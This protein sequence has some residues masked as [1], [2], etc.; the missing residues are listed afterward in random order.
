LVED[1]LAK[2]EGKSLLVENMPTASS[3]SRMSQFGQQ[4]L[5]I[6][7]YQ[8]SSR[9]SMPKPMDEERCHLK[10]IVST[11]LFYVMLQHLGHFVDYK[12][13][14]VNHFVFHEG[15]R[16]DPKVFGSQDTF[17]NYFDLLKTDSY[18]K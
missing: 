14:M 9:Q 4:Q 10:S 13:S 5:I 16:G 1:Y 6:Q 12:M 7:R 17:Q 15:H 18:F 2:Y 3:Q 11:T 8:R